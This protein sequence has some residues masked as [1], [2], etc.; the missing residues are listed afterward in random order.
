MKKR[1]FDFK[2]TKFLP[3]FVVAHLYS[4]SYLLKHRNHNDKGHGRVRTFLTWFCVL[5]FCYSNIG[6]GPRP[7]LIMR[8]FG[9]G[10]SIYVT[11]GRHY[12]MYDYTVWN[13]SPGFSQERYPG[14][15]QCFRIII[16]AK[17][18]GEADKKANVQA[19]Q[20]C[21]KH[22]FKGGII[23][24]VVGRIRTKDIQKPEPKKPEMQCIPGAPGHEKCVPGGINHLELKL[25]KP[26]VGKVAA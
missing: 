9:A 19:L 25:E 10:I 24:R 5:K 1:Y 4:L 17:S 12:Q 11:L 8:L 13:H 18:S 16:K 21:A 7:G 2:V 14:E 20:G 15:D 23:F 6:D 3:V 26:P 22:E